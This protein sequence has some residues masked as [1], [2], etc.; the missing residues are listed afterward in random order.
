MKKIIYDQSPHAR[1]EMNFSVFIF[2]ILYRDQSYRMR[3]GEE[4]RK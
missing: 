4:G 2:T 3:L 1:E